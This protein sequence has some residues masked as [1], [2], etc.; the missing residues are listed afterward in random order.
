M[1][2]RQLLGRMGVAGAGL[3]LGTTAVLESTPAAAAPAPN[4]TYPFY[5]E[6]QSGIIT[7]AQDR[8]TFATMNLVDGTTRSDLRDL[9]RDWTTAAARMTQGQLVGERQ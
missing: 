2:R 9:L 7:P 1:S 3:A 8:L 4:L 5:G 6:R